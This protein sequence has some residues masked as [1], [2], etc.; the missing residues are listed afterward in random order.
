[1]SWKKVLQLTPTLALTKTSE[2]VKMKNLSTIAPPEN[3]LI[4]FWTNVVVCPWTSKL[5]RL[6]VEIFSTQLLNLILTTML[7]S[8]NLFAL[9]LKILNVSMEYLLMILNVW[10]LA[11]VLS[12]PVSLNL[13][14]T[15]IWRPYFPFLMITIVLRKSLS[16]LLDTMV[17]SS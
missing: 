13:N 9:L 5:I 6:K 7:D 10:S 17:N 8:R 15:K 14:F 11:L 1:M 12:S 2:N 4:P 16:I 3:T